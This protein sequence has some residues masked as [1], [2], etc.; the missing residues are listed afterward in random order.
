M[1]DAV[2]EYRI[3]LVLLMQR[4][5]SHLFDVDYGVPQYRD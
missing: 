1:F 3:A 4:A 5:H 2:V